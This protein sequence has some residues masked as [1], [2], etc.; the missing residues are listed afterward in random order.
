MGEMAEMMHSLTYTA[1]VVIDIPNNKA[2]FVGTTSRP[3]HKITREIMRGRELRPLW[4]ER[5]KS[6]R[7]DFEIK[8]LE[9]GILRQHKRAKR[10]EF[11][12]QLR[13]YEPYG[14]N[15]LDVNHG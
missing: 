6:A 2:V 7:G 4:S 12:K 11:I 5:L 9:S 3:I 13:T 14:C 8:E 1:F 15:K 10:L